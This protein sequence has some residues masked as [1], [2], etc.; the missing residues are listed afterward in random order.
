M[1]SAGAAALVG[2]VVWAAPSSAQVQTGTPAIT[3]PSLL[4]GTPPPI[5]EYLPPETARRG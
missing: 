5:A 3:S 1:A 2:A 4:N